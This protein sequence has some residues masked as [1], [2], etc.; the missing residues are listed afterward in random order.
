MA[1]IKLVGIQFCVRVVEV[2]L[3]DCDT[4]VDPTAGY[5][6]SL[7]AVSTTVSETGSAIGVVTVEENG[8]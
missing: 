4:V 8:C 2:G 1:I 5:G 3:V 6:T 7:G